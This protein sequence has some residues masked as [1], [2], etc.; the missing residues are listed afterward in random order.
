MPSEGWL[1]FL[2][3]LLWTATAVQCG[4]AVNGYLTEKLHG[5]SLSLVRL[6]AIVGIFVVVTS[7]AAFTAFLPQDSLTAVTQ[8]AGP[9]SGEVA[10]AKNQLQ[11]I[12]EDRRKLDMREKETRNQL[13]AA[14]SKVPSPVPAF[15]SNLERVNK[16]ERAIVALAGTAVL[17]LGGFVVLAVGG[18]IQTLFPAA[19]SSGGERSEERRAVER[20]LQEV[21]RL[22]WNENYREALTKAEAIQDKKLGNFDRLDLLFLRGYSAVQVRSFPEEG[23]TAEQL[24]P[25]LDR[26]IS[27][28]ETVIDTAPKRGEA[29]YALALAY[30][31]RGS[32]LEAVAAFDKA[33]PMLT[34]D[35]LPFEHN[36]SVC[37][38]RLAEAS[39]NTG[40]TQ[41][42]E[43][44]FR[45]VA[46]L[47]KLSDSVVR[48]R[49]RV[50]MINL[51]GSMARQE[52]SSAAAALEQLSAMQDLNAEQRVQ[53]GAMRSALSARLA[54]RRDDPETALTACTEF[55][56]KHL[57]AGVPIPDEQSV[58]ETFSPILDGDLPFPREVFF[59]FFF[60]QAVSMSRLETKGRHKLS[61]AQ[62]T[63]LG[64]PLMRALQFAPR[65]RDMLGSVG[66][67]YYWFRR[68]KRDLAREWLESAVMM[69]VGGRIV[70]AI[71]EHDR[72]IEVERREA[73]DWFRSASSRFLRDP[74]IAGQVRSA[75]IEELGRFQEFE[76][77]LISLREQPELE[78]QEPTVEVLRERARYLAD[79]VAG[80]ARRGNSDRFARLAQVHAEYTACLTAL[81]GASQTMAAIES[82]VFGELGDTL[83]LS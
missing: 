29:L 67:L 51:R 53:I 58:E 47:G 15:I 28:L 68:E 19:W 52:V 35:Q 20:E 22:V 83:V 4:L 69:G 26:A 66:G 60:I 63:K 37:L 18:Q 46:E 80:F 38:L 7:L 65:Q 16:S 70:R 78:T 54:L 79:L 39:L 25:I 77:M 64:E 45:R 9:Q 49:L 81:E 11:Q 44:Y 76:P 82:K 30:G 57:P 24:R 41:Q 1:M 36:I 73:L 50:G 5:M 40:D 23:E 6:S 43:L 42:A 72:L 17:L 14:E 61:E 48:S 31:L 71:L 74:T 59:G 13:Y 2:L 32:D 8:T 62:I 27:D 34:T 3:W 75:L 56:Q 21:S 12:E 33:S 10:E 55:L